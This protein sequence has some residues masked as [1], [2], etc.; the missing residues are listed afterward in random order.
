[1]DPLG[2]LFSQK[3]YLRDLP[4]PLLPARYSVGAQR[5]ATQLQGFLRPL[6]RCAADRLVLSEVPTLVVAA[7]ADW[8][9]LSS[10]TYGLPLTRSAPAK[11]VVVLVAADYPDR[12]LHRF[13]DVRVRAA[14]AG[15]SA[16]GELR[17]FLDLLMGH[18]WGHAVLSLAGLRTRTHWFD[19]WLA[20]YLFLLTLT[21]TGQADLVERVVAWARLQVAGSGVV[22]APLSA[23][24]Y[25]RAKLRF[26]KLL[27]FQGVLTLRAAE[28]VAIHAWELPA[29]FKA[30]RAVSQ[31][32]PLAPTLLEVDPGFA[33][34]LEGFGPDEA[35]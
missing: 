2:D 5:R 31:K 20:V 12:L 23:F 22:S 11:R 1:M 29:A 21:E 9:A 28:L 8:V 33:A 7:R 35:P 10:F 32:R 13:D 15:I 6:Q 3:I 27:W 30:A 18:D 14:R 19:E 16:P 24:D 34:W 4:D 25:P 17:E 26:D